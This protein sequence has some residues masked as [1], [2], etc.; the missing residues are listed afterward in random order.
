MNNYFGFYGLL[1]EFVNTKRLKPFKNN[2][3]EKKDS[4]VL[5]DKLFS[6][7][8]NFKYWILSYNNTS[9]PSKEDLL[10][11][12]SKYSTEIQILERK[13]IYQITG[14]KN[15]KGNTEYMFIVKNPKSIL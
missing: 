2:F 14:K 5:F 1:D 8:Q 9:Y 6:N 7:L 3:I 10:E 4:L 15:K 11:V 12:I 13:H